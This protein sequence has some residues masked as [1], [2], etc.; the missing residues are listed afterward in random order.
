MARLKKSDRRPTKTQFR[1][2]FVL[3]ESR[4]PRQRVRSTS[5]ERTKKQP[6]AVEPVQNE[7]W[8]RQQIPTT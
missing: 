4:E 1:L 2:S 3:R 6:L 8:E 5:D 7:E